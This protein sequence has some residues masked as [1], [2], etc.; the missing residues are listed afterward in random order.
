MFRPPKHTRIH[1][2]WLS[3]LLA[4]ARVRQRTCMKS[5]P[6]ECRFQH[7]V[8]PTVNIPEFVA[9]HTGCADF[10]WRPGTWAEI[11]YVWWCMYSCWKCWEH[12]SWKEN[13]WLKLGELHRVFHGV[14][15]WVKSKEFRIMTFNSASEDIR[16]LILVGPRRSNCQLK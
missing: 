13:D 14:G 15:N 3:F 1:G 10:V 12:E 6:G 2:T 11:N 9:K 16:L 4:R 8:I 5:T 7:L